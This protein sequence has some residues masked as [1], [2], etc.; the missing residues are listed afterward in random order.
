MKK[1]CLLATIIISFFSGQSQTYNI[2][3]QP[4]SITSQKGNFIINNNTKIHPSTAS[5]HAMEFLQQHLQKH[6]DI[7]LNTTEKS[8]PHSIFFITDSSLPKEGYQLNIN[9]NK[10]TIRGTEAGFFYA[11]Q[12]IIQLLPI[13]HEKKVTQLYLPCMKIEDSPR[14]PYRGLHLDVGR[15]FFPADYIKKYIDY[16]ALHKLNTFHWHLTEDQG[17]RIEIK[18][19]PLL[20]ETGS[21]RKQTLI[22]NYG[23]GRYDNTPYCGFYTQQ[24]IRDIVAYA[25]KRNITIIPEIEMPGHSLAAIASYPFLSCTKAT[26]DVMQTWGVSPEVLCAGN[27]STYEFMEN[28]LDEVLLLFPSKYIH[29][30]GD[31]CPK[32]R[33]HQCAVCQQKIKNEHLKD[34]HELQSY[35]IRRIEQYLNSKGRNIIGW[36]EI[37]EG[38]LAP[39]ATVMSWRGTD[40][41]V[42]AAQQHHQAIMTPGQ[43]MYF[44][45]AQSAYEDSVT[46]GG[47]ISLKDVYDY[48][49][50]PAGL[51]DNEKQYIIGAQANM[52]TEY[53]NN[54]RKVEYMLFPRMAALSETLWSA[55]EQKNWER[56]TTGLPSLFSK[57]QK[58]GINYSKAFY[59]IECSVIP[60]YYRTDQSASQPIGI[61]WKLQCKDSSMKIFVTRPYFEAE[62]SYQNEVTVPIIQNGPYSA[63][64]I[65][66]KGEV[67]SNTLTQNFYTN[68]ATGKKA[69][70]KT[71]P[72][73]AYASAGVFTLVDGIHNGSGMSK[74]KE[75]LGFWGN[76]LDMTIDLGSMMPIE[77]IILH[78]FEQEASWIYPPSAVTFWSSEDGKDFS[79]F[80]AVNSVDG[81]GNF[82]II[83]IKKTQARFVRILAKNHGLIPL[84]NPGGGN[85][86]WLF[87]D[88]VEIF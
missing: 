60:R 43:L 55:P 86:S 40:G 78:V 63:L 54:T 6:Y 12:T 44:D 4:V 80:D 61:S 37:L 49:P 73:N 22:G 59:D 85:K 17:W 35:F 21:C 74:P 1:L 72:S 10:M 88:E 7:H 8:L 75:F 2:V 29:I 48:E 46:Q 70:L 16:L 26:F 64:L 50:I 62:D 77:T 38:G 65:N 14:F 13:T 9:A 28:V 47:L 24:E 81:K 58:W 27:D 15:H 42:A 56:F 69:E 71:P 57:Y 79:I 33:W 45:H 20:T 25:S 18:K 76:D 41:G 82:P 11:V 3:P 5:F 32:E 23:S 53:M 51:N 30:G 83:G 52:W 84:G 31:E 66:P 34:E 39:N 87:A 68:R 36:D 67:I 19:Y